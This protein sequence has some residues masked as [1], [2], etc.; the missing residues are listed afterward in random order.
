M[1]TSVPAGAAWVLIPRHHYD[2]APA[3]F[4]EEQHAREALA[5]CHLRTHYLCRL[6]AA[7]GPEAH[8]LPIGT[9]GLP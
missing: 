1:K 3:W 9:Q 8:R 4:A 7:A 2:G 6:E 5:R